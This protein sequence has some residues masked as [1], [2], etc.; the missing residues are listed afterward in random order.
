MKD[1][2]LTIRESVHGPVVREKAGKALA[3][4]VAGLDQ[5]NIMSQYWNMIRSRSL[6]GVRGRPAAAAD[7][8]LHRDVRGSRR[9]HHA[10]VRRP[11]A[12]AARPATTTGPASCRARRPPRCGR[13]RI[14]TSSC[15]AWS[16]RRA[17]GCRTPTIRR[18]RRR[19]RRRSIRTRFRA[20]WRRA[21]CRCARSSPCRLIWPATRRSR[22]TSSASTSTPRA[23]CWPIACW[24]T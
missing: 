7:A 9:A 6:R 17:A 5:P 20:T 4:R 11:H 18:G 13:R 21:A 19:F 16:I 1:E 22:S 2:A 8:V 10:S 24:M 14:P 23:C 3:L 15:R 12:G